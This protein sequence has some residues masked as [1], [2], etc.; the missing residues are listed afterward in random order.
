MVAL[1]A[2]IWRQVS[3]AGNDAE[4][5]LCR[6]LS[7]E[8]DFR[9]N[10]EILA[11]DLSHQMSYYNATAYVL[12]HLAALCGRLSLGE[13]HFLIAQT[14]AAIAA[15]GETPLVP[16][17]TEYREFHEGLDGLR[18]VAADLIQNHPEVLDAASGEEKQMFV[19]SALAILG[20]RK[21]AFA[22]FMLSGSCWEEAPAVC[23]CGW[24][25]ECILI[26]E[27]DCCIEPAEIPAWDGKSLNDEAVWV[28]GLLERAGDEDIAPI[29]PLV[30]GTGVC[31]ECGKREPYW[32]WN[33]RY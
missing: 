18:P 17:T 20:N 19:L 21:H 25:D 13:R 23:S 15:E 16:D 4:K 32:N 24:E 28:K 10:M 8:G 14:G 7:G 1:N 9:E 30:Y 2:P 29:I 6:L 33:D 26:R 5:W 3:S 22:L 31:P 27:P 11:E 12:P